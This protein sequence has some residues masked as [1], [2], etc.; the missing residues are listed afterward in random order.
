MRPLL[1]VVDPPAFDLLAGVCHRQEPGGIEAFLPD[2]AVERLDICVVARFSR[3]REVQFDLVQIGPLV[4]QTPRKLLAEV[5]TNASASAASFFCRF[6]KG[7]TDC[8]AIS[9]T[10]WPSLTTSRAE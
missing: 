8:G 1:N 6:T 7:R 4:E 2:P 3:A 5:D 9:R 10:S